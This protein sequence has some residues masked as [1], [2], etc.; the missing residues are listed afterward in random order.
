MIIHVCK[1]D[2]CGKEHPATDD[3]IHQHNL[4]TIFI[5]S[6]QTPPGQS[7]IRAHVCDYDCA[8]LFMSKSQDVLRASRKIDAQEARVI[9]NP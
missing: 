3:F 2:Q 4:I 5:P 1:C 9:Q 7:S 6:G 8:I